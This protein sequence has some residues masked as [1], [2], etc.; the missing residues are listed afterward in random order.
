[1]CL[2][3]S[4]PSHLCFSRITSPPYP[5]ACTLT[6]LFHS[7]FLW[8]YYIHCYIYV[9]TLTPLQ[10]VAYGQSRGFVPLTVVFNTTR[11]VFGSVLEKK[12]HIEWINNQFKKESTLLYM[13]KWSRLILAFPFFFFLKEVSS[14]YWKN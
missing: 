12:I 9:L 11:T 2:A 7:T 8:N 3:S 5:S 6:L 10:H 14:K 13:L 4:L 1:M